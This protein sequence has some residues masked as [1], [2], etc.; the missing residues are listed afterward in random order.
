MQPTLTAAEILA[1]AGQGEQPPAHDEI[2]S[3]IR[4]DYW[5]ARS[6]RDPEYAS[7]VV[8]LFEN[9]L[10]SCRRSAVGGVLWQAYCAYH[11]LDNTTGYDAA[12]LTL[13]TY[14]GAD[15]EI[16]LT[17]VAQYRMLIKHKLQLI[18]GDRLAFTPQAANTDGAA[19][20]QVNTAKHV[21]DYVLDQR[22]IAR[23]L[24]D[25][26]ETALVLGSSYMHLGWDPYAGNPTGNANP[27]TG[28]PVMTGDLEWHALTPFEC[29]H[30]PVRD[31][32][33]AHWHVLRV[34]V[35]RY[36]L[37]QKLADRGDT[38][39]AQKILVQGY[40]PGDYQF[41]LP[42]SGL[43]HGSELVPVYIAYH[44]RTPSVPAGRMSAITGDA[45]VVHD[46][47]LPYPR[48]PVFR[49]CPNEF[50]GTAQPFADSWTWLALQEVANA[51]LSP[52]VSRIDAFGHP[53]ISV[54]EGSDW[55]VDD[56]GGY[57]IHERPPGTEP[58]GLID[59]ANIPGSIA[60]VYQLIVGELERI[61]GINSV[62]QGKPQENITSGS[63]AALVHAQALSFASDD[64]E[65][66]V[67][68]CENTML[69]AIQLYQSRATEDLLITIAGKEGEPSLQSFK[70]DS[71][72]LIKR[73]TVKRSNP[74]MKTTAAKQDAANVLM[75]NGMI[76][77]PQEYLS[78]VETGTIE[79]AFTD[80][81]KQ[82]A[83]V[84]EENALL[85]QGINPPVGEIE[86]FH[87]HVPEHAALLDM[88]AKRNPQIQ[89]AIL[90]H[91]GA[92][93]AQ[94]QKAS[95]ENPA[96]LQALKIPVLPP[97]PQLQQKMAQAGVG[98]PP[99]GGKPGGKPG[100]KPAPQTPGVDNKAKMPKAP[101]QPNMPTM[102]D[103]SPAK[104]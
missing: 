90:R 93:M 39:T 96:L 27:V 31:Y 81:T 57:R 24:R 55:D 32:Q 38:K 34:F 50:M 49:M 74:I 68:L 70:G 8:S 4:S 22:G 98:G 1:L 11:L 48:A 78:I 54:P 77:T 65:Q 103:G 62:V 20:E 7:D 56:F 14:E 64:V 94:W 102:P 89:D 86:P 35:N 2:K 58:P 18:A 84:R 79:S 104:V 72:S 63:M 83:L 26:G 30:Q 29:V 51:V 9:H 92:T 41:T 40:T 12:P 82:M 23:G 36:D 61:S 15:D 85:L 44:D 73:V 33:H 25:C 43:F 95:L 59:M 13:P 42:G 53:M 47:P 76:P 60:Q 46:G 97:S 28:H 66:W 17:D 5:A 71:V 87:L 10:L 101:A 80:A 91:V 88:Y 21:I 100:P 6:Y 75:S 99:Q 37:A 3:Q 19:L 67:R 45:L 16:V 52:L 69:G